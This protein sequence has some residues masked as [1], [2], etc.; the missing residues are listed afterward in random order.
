[1]SLYETSIVI[2]KGREVVVIERLKLTWMVMWLVAIKNQELGGRWRRWSLSTCAVGHTDHSCTTAVSAATP[3]QKRYIY[4]D[5][6]NIVSLAG[7][8][9]NEHRDT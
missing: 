9:L 4:T 8:L 3:V 7:Y 5:T 2:C 6:S 1:M